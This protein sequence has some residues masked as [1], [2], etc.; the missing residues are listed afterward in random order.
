MVDST[1]PRS[2][3]KDLPPDIGAAR[4]AKVYAQAIV[5]ASDRK[6]CR[7]EVIAELAH[8]VRELLPRVPAA[9]HVFASPRVSEREKI[10]MLDTIFGSTMLPTTL[11]S[12]KVLARHDRLGILP[13]VVEAAEHLLDELAGRRRA[14][15][16]TAVDLEESQQSMA[17]LQLEKL[18]GGAITPTFRVDPEL[19][20]GMIVRVG[21]TVFDDSVA[22]SLVRLGSR[23]VQRSVHEI[24]YRRDRLGSA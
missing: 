15:F 10:S 21:D 16:L 8:I 2:K 22:T 18:V 1:L 6:N 14:T 4:I 24:Q 20:G 23:L 9:L 3:S 12:L 17:V 13:E 7:A 19:L 5:E 11:H